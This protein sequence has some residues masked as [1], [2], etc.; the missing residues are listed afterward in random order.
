[1]Q[2]YTEIPSSAII[3]ES[4]QQILNNDKTAISCHSGTAFPVVNL[5]E[6]MLCYRTDEKKLYQ[7]VDTALNTWNCIAD[8]SGNAR[9]LDG[10]AGNTINY[11]TKNLNSWVDM[12]TGF[13]QGTNMLNAPDG[14]T[15][16]RVIQIREGN[17]DGYS[18]QIAL[19]V[20][21]DKVCVRRQR[22]G[23]WS[24]W[25]NLWAGTENKTIAG[26]D[27]DRV[28]GKEPGNEK[29]K[30][31]L[32]N[33]V[34][35]ENLN[36]DKVDGYDVGSGAAQIPVNNGVLNEN[37]NADKVDGYDVGNEAGK[38]PVSNGKINTNLNAEMVGGVKVDNLIQANINGDVGRELNNVKIRNLEAN[39]IGVNRT[40]TAS[41]QGYRNIVSTKTTGAI[42]STSTSGSGNITTTE[43]VLNVVPGVTAG[44]YNLWDALQRLID[45]SHTHTMTKGTVNENCN[46]R[47][48]CDCGD[49][50]CS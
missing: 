3:A 48:D 37:L 43:Y 35:N 49:D 14:D 40:F 5:W 47:C 19:S 45:C 22:G 41:K 8:V 30:I 46:C 25:L 39:Y 6:G 27:A 18:S 42:D 50:N 9:L 36:A 2:K 7:L 12:P 15:T 17:S 26:L 31:A 1:M 34:L 20:N 44:R 32:N 13:Y 38:I 4:L 28:D 23:M 21:S 33:G 29:N 11:D 10:G 16:W 24:D